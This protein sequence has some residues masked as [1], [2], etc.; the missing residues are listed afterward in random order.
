MNQSSGKKQDEDQEDEDDDDIKI[1]EPKSKRPA[2][3]DDTFRDLD[4]S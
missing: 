4:N 2:E 3:Y 1:Y